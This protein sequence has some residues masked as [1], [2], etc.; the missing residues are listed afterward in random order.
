MYEDD[1]SWP[2]KCPICKDEFSKKI[3][4]MKAGEELRC[5]DGHRIAYSKE[6]FLLQLAEAKRGSFDPWGHMLRVHK[7]PK[8]I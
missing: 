6:Q 3:G 4:S 8:L 7:P 1:D 5:S 2:I